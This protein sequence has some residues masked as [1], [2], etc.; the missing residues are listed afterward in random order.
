M[1]GNQAVVVQIS[2]KVGR[3]RVGNVPCIAD[4]FGGRRV[5]RKI[6]LEADPSERKF[7]GCRQKSEEKQGVVDGTV[8]EML[9][10]R[11]RPFSTGRPRS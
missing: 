4:V 11:T 6:R 2:G 5:F 7:D 9:G 8:I 3:A 10:S 1:L